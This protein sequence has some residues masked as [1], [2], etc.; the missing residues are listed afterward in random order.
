MPETQEIYVIL[1]ALFPIETI[2]ITLNAKK[3]LTSYAEDTSQ[4]FDKVVLTLIVRHVSG[5]WYAMPEAD[6]KTNMRA[7]KNGG[8]IASR[9]TILPPDMVVWVITDAGGA[10]TTILLPEEY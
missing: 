4:A 6:Q 7:V 3:L 2:E 8:R 1:E 5:D 9:Y 10:L